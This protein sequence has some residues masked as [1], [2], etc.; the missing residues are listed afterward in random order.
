MADDKIF[1]YKGKTID[2][3]K[4]LSMEELMVIIPSDLRRKMK[5]GLIELL[6]NS[7]SYVNSVNH[8]GESMDGGK[9]LTHGLISCWTIGMLMWWCPVPRRP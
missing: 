6:K 3:L 1:K 5:R 2:E 4:K 7:N 8:I 9:I